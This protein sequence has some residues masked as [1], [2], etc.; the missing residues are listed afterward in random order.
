MVRPWK[1]S[2]KASTRVRAPPVEAGELEGRL[3]GLC[4]GVAEER[5]AASPAPLSRMSRRR[6]RAPAV[7]K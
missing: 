2:M 1:E 7:A 6:V 5:A 3:I 4:A